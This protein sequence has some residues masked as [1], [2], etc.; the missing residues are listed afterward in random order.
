MISKAS[1]QA[2][3][4]KN[5]LIIGDVMLD[6]YVYGDVNRISP[7]AP[8]PVLRERGRDYSIGGAANVA[9]NIVSL[10]GKADLIGIVGED[11]AGETITRLCSDGG[12]NAHL[13]KSDRPTTLKTRY[14][15]NGHQL[16]RL[17]HEKC[18][19]ISTTEKDQL[20]IT[21]SQLLNEKKYDGII[22]QD[23]DKGLLNPTTIPA[24][25][26]IVNEFEIPTFVDPKYK[27][28]HLYKGVTLIKPNQ[29]ELTAATSPD[30]DIRL[31]MSTLKDKIKCLNIICTLSGQGMS[32]LSDQYGHVPTNDI[33]VKDVSGAGDTAMAAI[34]LAY[35]SGMSMDVVCEIANV[36]GGIV[37]KKSKVSSVSLSE[38]I[39]STIVK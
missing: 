33:E 15:S 6:E 1:L 3:A 27:N 31:M 8:V 36:A 22:L 28:I 11:H 4:D 26:S 19:N 30:M 18:Q 32:Y 20:L 29:A 34:T 14:I 16:L 21:I 37:C 24:I 39:S 2:L 38:L 7:E 10:D 23:Y 13:L 9:M 5:I 12:I 17:D 25:L 35:I